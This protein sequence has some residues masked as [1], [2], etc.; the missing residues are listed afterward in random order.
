MRRSRLC[1]SSCVPCGTITVLVNMQD[2]LGGPGSTPGRRPRLRRPCAQVSAEPKQSKGKKHRH[3]REE[4]GVQEARRQDLIREGVHG[5][6][7]ADP[8]RADPRGAWRSS[9]G[10]RSAAEVTTALAEPPDRSVKTTV[11]RT[12]LEGLVAKSHARRT[13]GVVCS[14]PR[15]S[16]RARTGRAA[17]DGVQLEHPQEPSAG[18]LRRSRI[19]DCHS[20]DLASGRQARKDEETALVAVQRHWPKRGGTTSRRWPCSP[21]AAS[22]ARRSPTHGDRGLLQDVQPRGL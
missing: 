14:S 10:P 15:Q 20:A 21:A 19:R 18:L 11:V 3:G 22:L 17:A 4:D 7:Q 6:G 5:S 1:R 8:R 9:R 13:A 12:T 16:P 2:A